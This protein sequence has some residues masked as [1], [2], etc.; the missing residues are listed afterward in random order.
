MFSP[1]GSALFA[2][3]FPHGSLGQQNPENDTLWLQF[4]SKKNNITPSRRIPPK[5]TCQFSN[6]ANP[7]RA[8][9]SPCRFRY[10]RTSKLQ[11]GWRAVLAPKGILLRIHSGHLFGYQVIKQAL[12]SLG[13]KQNQHLFNNSQ[14]L[15]L[16]LVALIP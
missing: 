12:E 8:Q 4:E 1:S 2:F 9:T 5:R 7:V 14:A 10:G 11:N 13:A 3:R 15:G 6:N 16:V